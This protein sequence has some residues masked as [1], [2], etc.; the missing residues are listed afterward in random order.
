MRAKTKEKF[1]PRLILIIMIILF[2]S[3]V[4]IVMKPESSE[5]WEVRIDTSNMGE[6]VPVK[7][8]TLNSYVTFNENYEM[9]YILGDKGNLY[10][11]CYDGE[12]L[13]VD[14]WHPE[15]WKDIEIVDICAERPWLYAAA[16]DKE[17]NIYV[18][19]KEYLFKEK[20]D[21][22]IETNKRENW[23]IQK[24]E[25]IPKVKE[26]YATHD[27]FVIVTKEDVCMWSSREYRNP[28]MDD[29]EMIDTETPIIN[30]AASEEAVY[31]LD[32]EHVLWSL[33]NGTKHVFLENVE[34]I[35][36]GGKGFALRLMD[37]ENEVYVYNIGLLSR[38]YETTMLADGIEAARIVFEDEISSIAINK[39]A[40]VVCTDKQEFY[41]WGRKESPHN[42]YM[43]TLSMSLYTEPVKIDIADAKYYMVIGKNIVYVDGQN[44]MFFWAPY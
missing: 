31:I 36:Q 6:E 21:I 29:M 3:C 9:A 37:A 39:S 8:V 30:A 24:M 5:P 20:G 34:D 10:V 17:G 15:F 22:E 11:L 38:G 25:N 13:Y 7:I 43:Y 42:K 18:W 19:E 16:L 28:S 44:R 41:L 12:K 14:L 33:Q 23:K 35:V 27:R 32:E 2:V 4:W 40:A 1:I 26:I